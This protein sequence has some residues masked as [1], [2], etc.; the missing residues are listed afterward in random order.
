M[1]DPMSARDRDLLQELLNTYGPGGQEDAVREIC[2]RE[3]ETVA[4]QLW[5]DAAGNVVGLI[6]GGAAPPVRVMGD[7]S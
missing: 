2:R 4:D 3:L 1:Q 7:G 5:V 6:R